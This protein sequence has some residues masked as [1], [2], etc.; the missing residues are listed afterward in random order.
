MIYYNPVRTFDFESGTIVDT[1]TMSDSEIQRLIGFYNDN[2][3]KYPDYASAEVYEAFLHAYYNTPQKVGIFTKEQADDLLKK[4]IS[5]GIYTW[6]DEYKEVS[7][8]CGSWQYMKIFFTDGTVKTT[9]FYD[10]HPKDYTEIQDA[11]RE[12]FHTELYCEK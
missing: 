6:K 9:A 2:P 12:H 10:L 5:L 4:V 8:T 3:A 11:F 1:P 7:Y